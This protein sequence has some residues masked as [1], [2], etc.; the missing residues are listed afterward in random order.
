M[1]RGGVVTVKPVKAID[2]PDKSTF[3]SSQD[4]YVRITTTTTSSTESDDDTAFDTSTCES[5]GCNP[6]WDDDGIDIPFNA[7]GDV[8]HLEVRNNNMMFDDTLGHV[9]IPVKML[10]AAAIRSQS[11][12]QQDD[13]G[14]WYELSEGGKIQLV[15]TC[16]G[17]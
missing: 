3:M 1:F 8:V 17:K 10:F 14:H 16:N 15:L 6:H 7:G 2:L 12:Q 13:G 5:G 9:D 4:P 11:Q